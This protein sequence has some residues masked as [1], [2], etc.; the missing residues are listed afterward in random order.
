LA[1]V[2]VPTNDVI[3]IGVGFFGNAIVYDQHPIGLLDL[4]YLRLNH[5]PQF[6]RPKPLLR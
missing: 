2:V 6:G 4:P 5:L 3:L 1:V